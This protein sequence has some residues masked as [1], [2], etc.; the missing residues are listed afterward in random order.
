MPLNVF[1]HSDSLL[2]GLLLM[3]SQLFTVHAALNS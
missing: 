2:E 1:R 3:E